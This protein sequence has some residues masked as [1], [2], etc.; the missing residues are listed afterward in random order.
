MT[1]NFSRWYSKVSLGRAF[2]NISAI[3]SFIEIYS[4]F[5]SFSMTFSLKKWYLIDICFVLE[6]ITRFFQMLIAFVL[7]Q[8]MEIGSSYTIV[9]S[10]NVCFIHRTCVQQDA[11]TI[12]LAL[13]VDKETKSCFLLNH[14]T[15]QQPRKNAPPLVLFFVIYTSSPIY[16]CIST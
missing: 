4:S 13:V 2:I 11:T 10:F 5:T 14:T 9:I 12:Y 1:P 15:N 3:W 6:Y 8:K 7:S 16:I